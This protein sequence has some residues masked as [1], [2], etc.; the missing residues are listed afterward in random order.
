M[1][2]H[3]AL[4]DLSSDHQSL[5]QAH[6]LQ[7]AANADEETRRVLADEFLRFWQEHANPHFREEEEALLPF[8]ARYG[9]VNQEPIRQMQREHIFIRRDVA[10]LHAAS[11]CSAELLRVLGEQLEAHVRLEERVVFPLIEEAL[12]ADALA[13]LPQVLA[14]WQSE[15]HAK[16]E[17]KE[18]PMP[19]E[20]QSTLPGENLQ[21]HKMP[22]HWLLA[23]LGKKVLRPGGLELT[24]H[25]LKSLDIQPCDAV[26]EFAPGMG[27]T[28]QLALECNPASYIAIE[29]D[30]AAAAAL[31]QK[32]E[33]PHREFRTGSAD[34]TG[35]PDACAT[36]VYG[37]AMLTMQ[38]PEMKARIVREAARLLK[39]GG[40]Y[41]IHELCLVPDELDEATERE[42]AQAL[43]GSI[44]VGARPL[45]VCEWR[46]LL[47][48]EGLTVEAEHRVPMEL[49]E[50]ARL[51]ADEGV[52][53]ALHIVWNALHDAEALA[54]VREMRAVFRKYQD[55]LAA[56]ALVGLR[57]E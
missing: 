43:G 21:T 3:S 38:T 20:T 28:A 39:A 32:L 24:R 31:R 26:V 16:D 1:K 9:D 13:A 11:T 50:P 37:E 12:P 45:R 30:E 42:I 5:V 6:R 34:A 25:L 41:G 4:R 22:G 47:E 49:L 19:R 51:I 23:R 33:A 15:T 36:V 2:R 54:R 46:A 56:I 27:A 48:G 35:L 57:S 17:A 7:R 8:F 29:R 14:A 40:R 44:H 53:G 18:K 10:A 55:H 52:N